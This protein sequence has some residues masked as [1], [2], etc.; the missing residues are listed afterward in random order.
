MRKESEQKD[1][2]KEEKKEVQPPVVQ[3]E[4]NKVEEKK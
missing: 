3:S 4:E 1:E 2:T